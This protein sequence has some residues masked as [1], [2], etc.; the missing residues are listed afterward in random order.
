MAE[1]QVVDLTKV[2]KEP[3]ITHPDYLIEN[4]QEG[5][6]IPA[7]YGLLTGTIMTPI[8]DITEGIEADGRAQKFEG[9]GMITTKENKLVVQPPANFI[10]AYKTPYTYAV[11]TKDGIAII[12]NN[13]TIKTLKPDQINNISEYVN[14]TKIKEWYK[15]AKIG[16]KIP[17]DFSLSNFSDGRREVPPEDIVKFFG[18][19]TK[20][21]MMEYPS[22]SPIMAY[23]H[24]YK[25][26]EVA[27]A[28]S[29]LESYPEYGDISRE[30]NA[31]EFVRA[32]N[33][34]IVPPGAI[35]P[36]KETVQFTSSGDPE[37]PGGYASHGTCPPARALRDAVAEAGLP[38]PSGITWGYFALMYG[39]DPATDVKVYND[40]N[41]PIMIIMWTEGSGPGMIIHAKIYRLVPA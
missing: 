32:W 33:G 30:Y 41:Y 1:T 14:A 6:I 34:T 10:W 7:I 25:M 8:K 38:T 5:Q 19:Q 13:K 21:Y 9:P 12:E 18:E 36:G 37:A 24:N 22:G 3:L 40:G 27:T 4:L 17:I 15:E 16:D 31:R 35:S 28:T 29:Q 23:M 2:R 39:Y 11:K 20:K 26:E